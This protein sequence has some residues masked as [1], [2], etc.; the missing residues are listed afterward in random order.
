MTCTHCG[1]DLVID[2]LTAKCEACGHGYTL[3][4]RPEEE[5]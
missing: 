1:A 2:G 3:R 5:E 4:V